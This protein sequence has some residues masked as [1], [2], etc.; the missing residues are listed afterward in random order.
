MRIAI[1]ITELD[2]GGAEQCAVNLATFLANKGHTVKVLA[3]GQSPRQLVGDSMDRQI[4]SRQL[5]VR[6][7]P[8]SSGPA[9]GWSSLFATARWLTNELTQFEPEVIQSMLFHANVLTAWA[10]TRLQAKHFGG[11]RVVQPSWPRR[12][13]QNWSCKRMEKLVCVSQSV[14]ESCVKQEGVLR[15][16]VEVIPN[17][18]DLEWIDSLTGTPKE[19]NH[20]LPPEVPFLIFVGRLNPQK[21]VEQFL[22]HAGKLLQRLP[23]H[24]L[25]VL[26]DGPLKSSLQTVVDDSGLAARVHLVG[27]HPEAVRWIKRADLLVLPSKYEGMPNVVL[28][29]MSLCKPIVT[30]RVEGVTELLGSSNA[31]V[32]SG[33][34][35]VLLDRIVEI[36]SN[37]NLRQQLGTQNRETIYRQFQIQ[38]QFARYERLYHSALKLKGEAQ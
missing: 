16:K 35:S 15:S 26:G 14:A 6:G 2:P 30:F 8:W 17:G 18:I 28:E 25:V 22:K 29:A 21:G 33:D 12:R 10:N 1:T 23:L 13:L 32:V 34:M 11:A 31:Q 19:L 3:L 24:H 9:R 36:T 38:T 7:I 20:I 4:L 27:W 37:G 5:E